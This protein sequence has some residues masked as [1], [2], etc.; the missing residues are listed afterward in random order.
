[1]SVADVNAA[2]P[3]PGSSVTDECATV[4]SVSATV[5]VSDACPL[6]CHVDDVGTTFYFGDVGTSAIVVFADPALLT[7]AQVTTDAVNALMS[8]PI[9][10]RAADE[11]AMAR[12]VDTVATCPQ[13]WTET[14]VT[15][16]G[17]CPI[18]FVV[19][20][21][22][23]EI[24]VLDAETLC[25]TFRPSTLLAFARL[26]NNTVVALPHARRHAS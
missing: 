22:I 8:E 6:D 11:H 2:G 10:R 21:D 20:G 14:A 9:R 4:V 3:R 1:M 7:L 24:V 18:S 13:M 25:L 23:V 17:H 19:D 26:V 5:H 16:A 15:V 12:P